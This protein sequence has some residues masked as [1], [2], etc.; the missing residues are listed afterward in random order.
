ML[1]VYLDSNTLE[2]SAM[3]VKALLVQDKSSL[4]LSYSFKTCA[5][6]SPEVESLKVKVLCSKFISTF[7]QKSRK[8]FLLEASMQPALVCFTVH[9][10][11]RFSNYHELKVDL[12]PANYCLP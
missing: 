9:T 1:Q 3:L 2:F 6:N 10:M 4:L 8:R 7:F 11:C 5:P 12:M